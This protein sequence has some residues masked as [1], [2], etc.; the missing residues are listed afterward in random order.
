MTRKVIYTILVASIVL[1]AG[2]SGGVPGSPNSSPAD[3]AQT[4]APE[5]TDTP[6]QSGGSDAGTVAFYLSDERNAIGDFRSLNVTITSVG[7][8]RSD[9]G[10]WIERDVDNRTADLTELQGPNATLIDEYDLPNGTYSK[11]FVHVDDVNGTLRSGE[12]VRVKLPSEKLQLT[13]GFT[14]DNGSQVDFVFD[15]TVHRAGNSG[16]SILKPVV[17]ESGTDVPIESI[18]DDEREE[19]TVQF[20]GNVT[21]GENATLEV[22][23]NGTPVENATVSVNDRAVGMTDA[24]GRL[25]VAIPTDDEVEIEVE[26]GDAEGELE[27]EFEEDDEADEDDA[28][29]ADEDD[30]DEADEDDADEA[31][32]QDDADEQA[33]Q[34]DSAGAEDEQDDSADGD[35]SA[36]V[37]RRTTV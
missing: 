7:F 36:S 9:G 19:L 34:G 11:V 2:C 22:T 6:M 17:S 16:K 18:D 4:D 10:G 29:E 15:I 35:G 37:E 27:V 5:Q 24:D 26:K 20:R 21:Q 8:E 30:A 3:T 28:D 23:R 1:L 25:T 33:E 31:D 14:I 12:N 32:E 13:K